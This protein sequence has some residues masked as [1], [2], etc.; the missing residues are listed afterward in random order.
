MIQ[1]SEIQIGQHWR[2]D[3]ALGNT[4]TGVFPGK[5]VGD[6]AH[7]DPG[8]D[9]TKKIRSDDPFSEGAHQAV[10]VDVVEKTV[11]IAT[12]KPFPLFISDQ[13]RDPPNSASGSA[14]FPIRIADIKK[15]P[16][17]NRFEDNPD[18]LLHNLISD[19]HQPK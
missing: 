15:H 11:N 1:R 7:L 5:R 8:T 9:K 17:Q 19:T 2:D 10:V 3:A 4:L 18:R 13:V 14:S 16:L 6:P 12:G